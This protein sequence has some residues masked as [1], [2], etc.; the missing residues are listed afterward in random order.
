MSKKRIF[1]KYDKFGKLVPKSLTIS[2]NDQFPMGGSYVEILRQS[3]CCQNNL[4][5]VVIGNLEEGST[6]D[7]FIN[8]LNN[9]GITF[10]NCT[11]CFPTCTL[12]VSE[13]GTN[14]GNYVLFGSV[15]S[16]LAGL[17]YLTN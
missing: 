8:L 12:N 13:L 4:A 14:I 6:I 15:E 7:D 3:C 5:E 11:I 2:Q 9:G 16:I 17:Q 10:T 1:L